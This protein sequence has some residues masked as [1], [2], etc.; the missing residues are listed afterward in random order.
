MTNIKSFKNDDN[1]FHIISFENNGKYYLIIRTYSD[2]TVATRKHNIYR[3]E[4]WWDQYVKVFDFKTSAN[5]Y[6][7]AIKRNYHTI[8]SIPVDHFDKELAEKYMRDEESYNAK[9]DARIRKYRKIETQFG[10]A[11]KDAWKATQ[12]EEDRLNAEIDNMQFK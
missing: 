1:T 4:S 3:N 6:F 11:S 9:K 8:K 2:H 5:A 10:E 7:M 12:T